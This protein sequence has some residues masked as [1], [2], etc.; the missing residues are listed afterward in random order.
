MRRLK[1]GLV[2]IFILLLVGR[3]SAFAR[4][5][6]QGDQC[7]IE[8]N[9]TVEGNLFALCR[10]LQIRG[11]ING[12]VLGAA[13]EAKISGTAS[14]Q[15]IRGAV[16]AA[17]ACARCDGAQQLADCCRSGCLTLFM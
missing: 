14:G 16:T 9:E 10:T 7:I 11:T 12:D 3:S 15:G 2:F 17:A 5:I 13:T 1:F 8:A 6:R 4:A